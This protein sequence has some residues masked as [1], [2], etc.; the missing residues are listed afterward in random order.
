MNYLEKTTKELISLCKEREIKGYSGKKKEDIIKLLSQYDSENKVYTPISTIPQTTNKMKMIDLFS[1][2]G[3]FTLA[4]EQT[5]QVDVVFANDMVEQSKTIYDANFHHKLVLQDLNDLKNEDIPQHD[6]L[7]GGFPC[8]PF[9]IAGHQEGF[10]DKR[11]NVFWK[12]LSIIDHHNPKCVILENVKNLVS[13]DD[14]NTFQ[15][16]LENLKKST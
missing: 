9:S 4:F 7:T 14:K 6:I 12:I 11:S 3:A 5:G 1:G 8:Q 15:I 10:N 16:I 2:T 13:H